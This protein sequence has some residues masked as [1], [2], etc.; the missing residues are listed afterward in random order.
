MRRR[1][2]MRGPG[3]GSLCR[4]KK[5]P[6]ARPRRGAPASEKDLHEHPLAEVFHKLTPE[7]VLGA[8]EVGGRRCT[9]SFTIL[10]S[11]E[12]RVYMLEIEDGSSVVGK[13]YR[14]GRWSR[15]T[16]LDEHAFVRELQD[17]EIPA[18]A[19]IELSPGRT[20]GE[21]NGIL[22]ALFPR[23][24]GR[25]PQE[26]DDEQVRILGRLLA[27]MHAIG[28]RRPAPHRLTLDAE[29]YGRRNL[30]YLLS[31]DLIP[32][33]ARDAY[34]ATVH[35]LLERIRFHF[36]DVPLHRIHGDCHAGNLVWTGNGPAFLDFDDMVNGP[37]AQD[38]WMLVPSY[39]DEGRRQR[40]LL[41]DAYRMFREFPAEWLRQIEPLRALRYIHYA[42]W[43]ARR[44][45][46]PAFKKTFTWFGTVQ[47]WQREM[48]DLREQIASI[49]HESP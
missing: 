16:I 10:N 15:E 3:C 32:A 22:Y 36:T 6:P 23:V 31:H 9:G 12:N 34:V 40:E 35:A 11:Y 24:R 14:P 2:C 1:P 47:Y 33:E 43:I 45:G 4:V 37:A 41:I 20:L 18:T 21:V 49:D 7:Q 48:I 46:D 5:T 26:L 25:V 39:D 19:P 13:F 29:T 44:W 28:A 17:E 8:A 27:R 30:D 38:V 42:T